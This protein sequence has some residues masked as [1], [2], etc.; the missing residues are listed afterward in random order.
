[1]PEHVHDDAS[2]HYEIIGDGPPLLLIAGLASDGASWGPL[3]AELPERHLILVD[4]RGAGR[5]RSTGPIRF[6]DLVADIASLIEALGIGPVDVVGHSLG[7]A[8]GLWLAAEHP[9]FVARPRVRGARVV[10]ID[11]VITSGA[12]LRAA[13]R[14]LRAGGAEVVACAA[15]AATPR[16]VGA[17]SIPWRSI[18]GNDERPGDNVAREGY[19][20]GKE[21]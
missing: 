2:L 18:A 19:R 1:M 10:L 13:A 9:R 17:S 14:A 11:D 6:G 5:T 3:L 20:E 21:A 4:N 12:T 16:R 15:L 8:I 7:G